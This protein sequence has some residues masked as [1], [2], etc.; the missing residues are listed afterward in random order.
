MDELRKECPWAQKQTIKSLRYLTI[1]EVFEL[2]EAILENDIESIKKELGDLLFHIVFYT[3][4]VDKQWAFTITNVIQELCEKLMYRNPHIYGQEQARD[5]QVTQQNREK[6]KLKEKGNNSVLGGIPNMLPS[7]IKAMRI[8]E[9]VSMIGLDW[10]NKEEV[11]HRIQKAM[12]PLMHETKAKITDPQKLENEFGD[13]LFALVH[14]ARFVNV[15]AE[16]ALEEANK[17][18]IHHFQ[19]VEQQAAE[20]GKQLSQLSA[21]EL[22]SYWEKTKQQ[23]SFE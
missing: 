7:L 21:E 6:L 8:Q 3:I 9:K 18:F 15:N 10:Q 20:Q 14:Y 11:W 16:N 23:A 2:S 12:Q 5:I 13:L 17:K 4:I 22:M 1:E 19:H